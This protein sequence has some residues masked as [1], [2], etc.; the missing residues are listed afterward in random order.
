MKKTILYTLL[1]AVLPFFG[2][3]SC[4]NDGDDIPNVDFSLEITDGT[5][6]DGTIY[7]VRGTTLKIDGIKVKNLDGDKSAMITSATY[8]W[9]QIRLG[10]TVVAPYGFEFETT[11]NTP[12]GRHEI[13]I[14]CPVYAVD[15]SPAVS[16]IYYR[17]E[18]VEN[19]D[20]IPAVTTPTEPEGTARMLATN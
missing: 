16:T 2:F 13:T 11:E 3:T 10:T 18:V 17:V 12:L 1:L 6:V 14:E 4:S 19:A 5:T 7:V 20:D 15:K 8:Y 9:D